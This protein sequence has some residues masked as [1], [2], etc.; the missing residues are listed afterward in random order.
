[1][2]AGFGCERLA[3]PRIKTSD[4]GGSD[5]FFFCRSCNLRE[6]IVAK[7]LYEDCNCLS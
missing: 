1:M 7:V 4:N 2:V 3:G 5:A 6:L